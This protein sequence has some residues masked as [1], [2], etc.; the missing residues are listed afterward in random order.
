M[1]HL[2]EWPCDQEERGEQTG[3]A[4]LHA[5]IASEHMIKIKYAN[6]I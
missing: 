4:N 3:G 1:E 6:T 5:T 2:A